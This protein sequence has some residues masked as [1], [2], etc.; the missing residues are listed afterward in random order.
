MEVQQK[1]A[2]MQKYIPCLR[3]LIENLEKNKEKEGQVKKMQYLMDMLT[4]KDLSIKLET[5]NRCEEV[6]MKFYNKEPITATHSD[7]SCDQTDIPEKA[8]EEDQNSGDNCGSGS[9]DKVNSGP[10]AENLFNGSLPST[11][12]N[13]CDIPAQEEN[14]SQVASDL[15]TNTES[16]TAATKSNESP[17]LSRTEG[18]VGKTNFSIISYLGGVNQE[19]GTANEE[20]AAKGPVLKSILEEAKSNEIAED[21]QPLPS[22]DS[23]DPSKEELVSEDPKLESNSDLIE[24]NA[25]DTQPEKQDESLPNGTAKGSDAGGGESDME[26][27]EELTNS[28][29]LE[30]EEKPSELSDVAGSI[31]EELDVAKSVNYPS[32][33]VPDSDKILQML[34]ESNKA[35]EAPS[36][37]LP[38]EEKSSKSDVVD[39]TSDDSNDGPSSKTEKTEPPSLRPINPTQ[40][41]KRPQ[42]VFFKANSSKPITTPLPEPSADPLHLEIPKIATIDLLDSDSDD[43]SKTKPRKNFEPNGQLKMPSPK[44]LTDKPMFTI[45]SVQSISTLQQ[46]YERRREVEKNLFEIVKANEYQAVHT[47]PRKYNKTVRAYLEK[48]VNNLLFEKN[49]VNLCL[50]KLQM[51]VRPERYKQIK[52]IIQTYCSEPVNDSSLPAPSPFCHR[53]KVYPEKLQFVM[54]QVFFY[55]SAI[56][57]IGYKVFSLAHQHEDRLPTKLVPEATKAQ[58]K[59]TNRLPVIQKVASIADNIVPRKAMNSSKASTPSSSPVKSLPSASSSAFAIASAPSPKPS[60]VPVARKALTS[61]ATSP[62]LVPNDDLLAPMTTR[63][64]SP[65]PVPTPPKQSRRRKRP[66]DDDDDDD[67][68]Y[69][70]HEYISDS[71]DASE[72]QGDGQSRRRSLQRASKSRCKKYLQLEGSIDDETFIQAAQASIAKALKPERSSKKGQPPAKKAKLAPRSKKQAVQQSDDETGSNNPKADE[73]NPESAADAEQETESLDDSL[74][75]A[76]RLRSG[77]YRG[78]D[79][80]DDCEPPPELDTTKENFAKNIIRAYHCRSQ[81]LSRCLICHEKIGRKSGVSHYVNSH[82]D[83]ENYVSRITKSDVMKLQSET[84]SFAFLSASK[85]SV[86]TYVAYCFFCQVE[87]CLSMRNWWEHYTRHTGEYG[88]ECSACKVRRSCRQQMNR[89]VNIECT[90]KHA[91]VVVINELDPEARRID[92]YVCLLCFYIQLH[93]EPLLR[94]MH[95]EHGFS[96]N[97]AEIPEGTYQTVN[98]LKIEQT[99]YE[100]NEYSQTL[101]SSLE[102]EAQDDMSFM[103]CNMLASSTEQDQTSVEANG[104]YFTVAALPENSFDN[105]PPSPEMIIPE[106]IIPKSEQGDVKNSGVH[107]GVDDATKMSSLVGANVAGVEIDPSLVRVK[108]EKD[109]CVGSLGIPQ[110]SVP[111]VKIIGNSES[112][113]GEK[114]VLP[115]VLDVKKENQPPPG[116]RETNNICDTSNNQISDTS[117]GDELVKQDESAATIEEV[118]DGIPTESQKCDQKSVPKAPVHLDA[119]NPISSLVWSEDDNSNCSN[120]KD[121]VRKSNPKE[122]TPAKVM[123]IESSDASQTS[124]SIR[125]FQSVGN[126]KTE[127]LPLAS[128]SNQSKSHNTFLPDEVNSLTESATERIFHSVTDSIVDSVLESNEVTT[129]LSDSTSELLESAITSSASNTSELPETISSD[130]IQS[131][132]QFLKSSD[133]PLKPDLPINESDLPEPM[134][135]TETDGFL[136][137]TS[138]DAN[139]EMA[140]NAMAS[141]VDTELAEV[142]E[143]ILGDYDSAGVVTDAV[144]T[145]DSGCNGVSLGI[146]EGNEISSNDC[147]VLPVA[148]TEPVG[149]DIEMKDL[150]GEVC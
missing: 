4:R 137:I 89:H 49:R 18:D 21:S 77:N 14:N 28:I 121:T 58:P 51:C 143:T 85:G 126:K 145:A 76:G 40:V 131:G 112:S 82:R 29:A 147:S 116:P 70:P 96:A 46:H 47:V 138:L 95:T 94:H 109:A 24:N 114:D 42:A 86:S 136:I 73:N 67:E 33:H 139:S 97:T 149:T 53:I 130:S 140:D 2:E 69:V 20:S 32:S 100:M 91:E 75:S 30:T 41:L 17:Q 146:V 15:V 142:N 3:G 107:I 16:E 13:S 104:G 38:V 93:I 105:K 129:I 79:D 6:L 110:D 39:L 57:V 1:I 8:K 62:L 150:E 115:A 148:V 144:I 72:D 103:I 22:A 127:S 102:E 25:K 11:N 80:D 124:T 135:T 63:P 99:L 117:Q 59:P 119:T 123:E 87:H 88:F 7:G 48:F 68:N 128:Q 84:M 122:T 134:E 55:G 26:I 12:G 31:P 45:S 141:E 92:A 54:R 113:A 78:D 118:S 44:P 83:R 23:S 43:E 60:P 34:Q 101:E 81:Y 27:D 52:R 108:V 120:S 9:P 74:S 50:Q 71:E 5:L 65:D 133:S 61:R 106:F 36:T 66:S 125:A 90:E 10:E 64:A 35:M 37:S 19:G 98:M 56:S 132:P 111:M